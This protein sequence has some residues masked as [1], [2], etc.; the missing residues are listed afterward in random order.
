MSTTHPILDDI[1]ERMDKTIEALGREMANVRTG[2][3]ST[4]LLD[5]IDVEVYGSKMKLNQ[6]ATVAAPEARLL[7][8]TPWDKSQVSV[9]EK[10]IKTSPLELNP[11]NDGTMIRIPIPPLT[12]ERRKEM[13]KLIHKDAEEARVSIRNSRRHGVDEIKKEQK[14]G[15]IPED[16]AHHVSKEIQDVTDAYTKKIDDMVKAKEDELME[17]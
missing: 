14:N 8:V 13:V 1:R 3:A 17:V 4:G 12:E 7:T 16:D 2:R 5:T 15:D 11:S 9:I 6:L 10:A